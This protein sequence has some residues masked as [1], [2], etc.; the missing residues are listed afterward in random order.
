MYT[1]HADTPLP[2]NIYKKH[3][4]YYNDNWEMA[5]KLDLLGPANLYGSREAMYK[6]QHS[7]GIRL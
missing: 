1:V 6:S 2:W 5:I 3:D 4:M 7:A